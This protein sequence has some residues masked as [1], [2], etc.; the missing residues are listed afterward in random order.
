M[1][2]EKTSTP[3]ADYVYPISGSLKTNLSDGE[4]SYGV[5]FH[6]TNITNKKL[7][8]YSTSE[9]CLF[10]VYNRTTA[11]DCKITDSKGNVD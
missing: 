9:K 7:K 11:Y 1:T 10:K 8:D 5:N 4:N 2:A 6:Y 3:L